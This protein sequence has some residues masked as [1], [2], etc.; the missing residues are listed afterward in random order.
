MVLHVKV[1]FYLSNKNFFLLSLHARTEK[2]G[3]QILCEKSQVERSSLL[4]QVRSNYAVVIE[5]QPT[6]CEKFANFWIRKVKKP[7]KY[8]KPS[9]YISFVVLEEVRFR[10]F[11]LYN[12]RR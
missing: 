3:D 10:R 11:A 5:Y 12:K 2:S 1:Q 7:S 4:N 6:D 8:S 9:K